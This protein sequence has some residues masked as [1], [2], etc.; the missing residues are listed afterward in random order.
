MQMI[1][2]LK[3]LAELDAVNPNVDTGLRIVQPQKTVSVAIKENTQVEECG[4]MPMGSM[5]KPSTPASINMT[6]GSGE[7]LSSMIKAIA[8][9]AGTAKGGEEVITGTPTAG[10]SMRSV[11]DKLNPMGDDSPEEG[12]IGG[13]LG[14]A[15]G[16]M[17]GGL[18]GAA[19][20]YAAGS[21][22]GDDL[23]DDNEK[24]EA[25][26]NTP[27]DPTDS[28]EFDAEQHA[29]HENPAGADRKGNANNPRAYDTN[30]STESRLMAEYQRFISE[31]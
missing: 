18:P 13:A 11:I 1:D 15:A 4:M 29:H 3:R 17:M 7:E 26:D 27:T 12:L 14:G 23:E 19:L 20:G 8:T 22:V 16:A 9:L 31:N 25:Y 24:K 21:K 2:V 6:A 10:D 30:E 28:N 5:E